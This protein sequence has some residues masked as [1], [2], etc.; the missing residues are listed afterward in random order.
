MGLWASGKVPVSGRCR[1]RVSGPGIVTVPVPIANYSEKAFSPKMTNAM[2]AVL[3]SLLTLFTACGGDSASDH[4]TRSREYIVESAYDSAIIE[5]KNALQKDRQAGEARWLLG[6]IYLETGDA[7]S[8]EKELQRALQLGWSRDDVIPGLAGAY[9]AQGKDEQL[10]DLPETGLQAPAEAELLALQALAAMRMGEPFEAEKLIKDALDKVPG[11]PGTLLARARIF[12]WQGDMA[13]ADA[14]L[15]ALLAEQPDHAPAWNLRGDI[16]LEQKRFGDAVAAY[17][18]V[19]EQQPANYDVIF[20]RAMLQLQLK[21][22]EAARSGAEQVLLVVPHH[23]GANYLQGIIQ[24]RRG[25]YPEAITSLSVAEPYF[26]Q[27]PLVLF[28]LGSAQ[29]ME[30]NLDQASFHAGRFLSIVP[31]SVRGRKLLAI[32]R[33]RQGEFTDVQELLQPVLHEDPDDVEA[34]NLMSYA[35]IRDG[36]LDEGIAALSRVAELQPDSAAAQVRLGAGLLLGDRGEDATRHM[37]AALDIDPELQQAEILLVMNHLQRGDYP[38]AIEAAQAYRQRNMTS[39]VPL[40]LLGKVYQQ[41]G[42]PAEAREFF[43]RA[44]AFDE[45]DPSANHNLAQMA[46]A[47]GD[48]GAARAYYEAILRERENALAPLMELAMLDV[49]ERD[50]QSMLAHLDRAIEAH[51]NALRPRL[52]LARYHLSKGRPEKVAPLFDSLDEAR[53]QSPQVLAV[54]A[55]A[56]MSQSEHADAR[57]TLEQ[58]LASS[59]ETAQLHHLAALSA[60]GTGDVES[61]EAGLRRALA[62]DPDYLPSRVALA[63]MALADKRVDEFEQH[64]ARLR[65][66]APE[67]PDVLLLMAVAASSKGDYS[68]AAGLAEKAFNQ[69]PQASTLLTLGA[70]KD[71]A[72]RSGEV[73]PLY[74]SWVAEH[75]DDIAVRLA[76]A[77]R[78]QLS[79]TPGDS[80]VIYREILE[81]DPDHVV[82]LN[83]IA[84]ELREEETARAL[85]YARQAASL[86]PESAEVLDTL[87]VIEYIGKDYRQAR[88]SVERALRLKPGDP[89][90][91][92]H[93]AMI[94]AAMGDKEAAVQI[95][96]ELLAGGADFPEQEQAS[97]LL[98]SI[99]S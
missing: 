64:L 11:A 89:S 53:K 80:V 86:A 82:A 62:L 37:Q 67:Q 8:A 60:A 46:I 58:L 54:E 43:E 41:A 55:L 28:F 31:E 66:Q 73:V 88:R 36:K 9:Y 70:Y 48:L 6:R 63:R 22:F 96:Q 76:L 83:N 65:E 52:M 15:D 40:N 29:L 99:R 92:Y 61:A 24:F 91:R 68:G 7:L 34:L 74:R 69:A 75:A 16:R 50:E 3:L 13:G 26:K 42:E 78:L 30:G 87:A 94:T 1:R 25:E 44:L 49:R 10:R 45:A 33:L 84:W 77:G 90:M 21:E 81:L 17:S 47:D 85:E 95:L 72:G 20:K 56:Q 32:V 27:F 4:I 12:A 98:N 51:P 19:L 14:V 59:T 57:F 39:T 23:P 97:E 18:Q 35:L 38:A 79:A 93:H 2:R 71:A 5:L